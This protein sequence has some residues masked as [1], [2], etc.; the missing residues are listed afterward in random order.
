[1][2][3]VDISV[4]YD[5]T[6]TWEE[7]SYSQVLGGLFLGGGLIALGGILMIAAAVVKYVFRL[8]RKPKQI[9]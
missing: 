4:Q 8:E 3:P 9:S 7:R 5:I 6:V 1:M 2:K